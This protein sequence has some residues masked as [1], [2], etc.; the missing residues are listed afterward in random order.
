M[1]T[2][3]ENIL[4]ALDEQ[5]EEGEGKYDGFI[6]LAFTDEGHMQLMHQVN[7]LKALGATTALQL[8][9]ADGLYI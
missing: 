2:L 3:Q 7:P 1:A 6:L 5:R 9:L 8:K 4:A